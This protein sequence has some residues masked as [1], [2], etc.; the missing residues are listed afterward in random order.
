MFLRCPCLYVDFGVATSHTSLSKGGRRM[1]K[2]VRLLSLGVCAAIGAA[3]AYVIATQQMDRQVLPESAMPQGVAWETEPVPPVEPALFQ[4]INDTD[5]R[6][7]PSDEIPPFEPR[8][9][10]TSDDD[11]TCNERDS[12]FAD[13][14]VPINEPQLVPV[15]DT[16]AAAAANYVVEADHWNEVPADNPSDVTGRVDTTSA[17][18]VM[19]ATQRVVQPVEAIP[20]M[21]A[22][23]RVVQPVEAIAIESGTETEENT[24]P[25]VVC[26]PHNS[27]PVLTLRLGRTESSRIVSEDRVSEPQLATPHIARTEAPQAS[28]F[29]D[30]DEHSLVCTIDAQHVDLRDLLMLVGERAGIPIHS[31]QHVDGL[32]SAHIKDVRLE[33]AV[34]QIVMPLGFSVGASDDALI[35]G[36]HS[37]VH[38]Y[39]RRLN[40]FDEGRKGITGT[41]HSVRLVGHHAA[42]HAHAELAPSSEAIAD[43]VVAGSVATTGEIDQAV[44]IEAEPIP[45]HAVPEAA[46]RAKPV[47][48]VP[49]ASGPRRL[50]V[51]NDSESPR[52][53]A[54]VS[55]E[56]KVFTV[57]AERALTMMQGGQYR[58]TVEMLSQLVSDHGQS[59][60]LF[61]LL[62]EAYYHCGE[63]EAA[64]VSLTR[65]LEIYRNDA[66]TNY[67]MGCTF[68]ALGNRQ[69][70]QH[71]LLQ[72]HHLDPMYPPVVNA[73]A[74]AP[75]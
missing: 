15:P 13:A 11:L 14:M 48:A 59:A 41:P 26:D 16:Q 72:A 50:P 35:V 53:A 51:V 7:A 38:G 17:I 22:I 34:H 55:D 65:S 37:E 39:E 6:I 19:P 28:L 31:T 67:F 60:Q 47:P 10:T 25:Y 62:G 32:V 74:L 75:R 57:I 54:P 4:P 73:Q 70:G 12:G 46:V 1:I 24:Q 3:A 29:V 23:R 27:Q 8:V 40:G 71:Y 61:A 68:R 21:P 56:E 52:R 42:N 49:T 63:Y 5:A 36:L 44:C 30:V 64:E 45:L 18:P 66:R 2:P 9:A 58:R 43:S 33:E 20:V 69:R